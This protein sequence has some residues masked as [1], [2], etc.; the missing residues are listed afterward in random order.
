MK[1][2][3]KCLLHIN[4][5]LGRFEADWPKSTCTH[6]QQAITLYKQTATTHGEQEKPL[7]GLTSAAAPKDKSAA[8]SKVDWLEIFI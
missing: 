8:E 3:G 4:T 2:G 6:P 1:F 5:T 7:Y